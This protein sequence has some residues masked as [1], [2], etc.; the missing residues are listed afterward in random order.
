MRKSETHIYVHLDFSLEVT[1]RMY[2]AKAG[3]MVALDTS[4]Y[5]NKKKIS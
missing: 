3:V 4:N 2:V 5:Q 1:A